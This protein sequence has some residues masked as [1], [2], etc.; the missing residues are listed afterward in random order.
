M[1]KK[2]RLRDPKTGLYL[3]GRIN[4]YWVP[5]A[6]GPSVLVEPVPAWE[7]IPEACQTFNRNDAETQQFLLSVHKTRV[8]AVI[9]TSLAMNP[10][11]ENHG[12]PTV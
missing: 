7:R 12:T 11:G 5:Q 8:N 10:K 1:S 4:H 3:V 9:T 2:Y 6:T